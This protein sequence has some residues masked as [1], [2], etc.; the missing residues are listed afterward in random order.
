MLFHQPSRYSKKD[1]EI[2][3]CAFVADKKVKSF[4]VKSG[5]CV[6]YLILIYMLKSHI[7]VFYIRVFL[8]LPYIKGFRM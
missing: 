1:N 8:G 2:T 3:K 5:T 7:N 6:R 4:K